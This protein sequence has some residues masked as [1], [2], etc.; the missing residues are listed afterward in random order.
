MTAQ[1]PDEIIFDGVLRALCVLPLDILF[2]AMPNPPR[3]RSET[4]ANWRG[5]CAKWKIEEGRLWLVGLDGNVDPSARDS[6][7]PLDIADNGSAIFGRGDPR[8]E[9]ASLIARI[10]RFEVDSRGNRL[11]DTNWSGGMIS[12]DNGFVDREQAARISAKRLFETSAEPL[13][14]SWYSGL[15]RIPDGQLLKLRPRGIRLRIRT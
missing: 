15:L 3:F 9:L 13:F 5:Y 11:S 12:D 1:V 14:A 8:E 7:T 6:E 2:R 10:E 4:T